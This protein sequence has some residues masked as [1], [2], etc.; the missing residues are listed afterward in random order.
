MLCLQMLSTTDK[1]AKVIAGS[2]NT[3]KNDGTSTAMFTQLRGICSEGNTLYVTDVA[4][5]CVKI[6]MGLSGIIPLFN[7]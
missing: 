1:S 7:E 2:G 5:G 3:G 6:V 4:A